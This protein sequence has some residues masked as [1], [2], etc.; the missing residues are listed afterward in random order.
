MRDVNIL[1]MPT[2]YGWYLGYTEELR[3]VRT[4]LEMEKIG[5]QGFIRTA[6]GICIVTILGYLQHSRI[7]CREPSVAQG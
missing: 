7:R 1:E 3:G 5:R 2:G 6:Q 4:L